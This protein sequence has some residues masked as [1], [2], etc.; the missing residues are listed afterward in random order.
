MLEAGDNWGPAGTHRRQTSPSGSE[1]TE[2]PPGGAV[3]EGVM[4]TD[5]V[6]VIGV[7]G[8]KDRLLRPPPV[9]SLEVSLMTSLL[10]P[11]RHASVLLRATNRGTAVLRD[12]NDYDAR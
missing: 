12:D 10:L 9:V 2:V 5:V 3:N 4:S 7:G 1:G 11:V 8:P 6:V